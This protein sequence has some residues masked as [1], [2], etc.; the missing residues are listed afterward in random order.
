VR[1][2]CPSRSTMAR[3][4]GQESVV[5][6][7]QSLGWSVCMEVEAREIGDLVGFFGRGTGRTIP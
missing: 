6:V 7:H 4:V 3:P 1:S 2:S 5:R